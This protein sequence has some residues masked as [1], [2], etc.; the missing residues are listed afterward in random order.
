MRDN[1]NNGRVLPPGEKKLLEEKKELW[2]VEL[3]KRL[4]IEKCQAVVEINFW[5][6]TKDADKDKLEEVKKE[7]QQLQHV[8]MA[9]EVYTES[10]ASAETMEYFLGDIVKSF[11]FPWNAHETQF[12]RRSL[13]DER[14]K[15][16][17]AVL[18][19]LDH[20]I[21]NVTAESIE[22]FNQM[23][24]VV[25]LTAKR[26][27]EEL[28]DHVEEMPKSPS[29]MQKV[30]A[31]RIRNLTS[32]Y[33][34]EKLVKKTGVKGLEVTK[35]GGLLRN[36]LVELDKFLSE[37]YL[38]DKID[39][40]L[41]LRLIDNDQDDPIVFSF[42]LRHS[43]AIAAVDGLS[44]RV[45][46]QLREQIDELGKISENFF[47][48]PI[49]LTKSMGLC[50]AEYMR[51]LKEGRMHFFPWK[52]N[53][54]NIDKTA[55]LIEQFCKTLLSEEGW[56]AHEIGDLIE[57]LEI[58]L[59]KE[60]GLL[61]NTV[62]YVFDDLSGFINEVRLYFLGQLFFQASPTS[63]RAGIY[64]GIAAKHW[65]YDFRIKYEKVIRNTITELVDAGTENPT[66]DDV[67]GKIPRAFYS[68]YMTSI[69]NEWKEEQN[70]I[71]AY[72][73]LVQKGLKTPTAMD[74]AKQLGRWD[75]YIWGVAEPLIVKM[76]E[77]RAKETSATDKNKKISLVSSLVESDAKD[78]NVLPVDS[79]PKIYI[80]DDGLRQRVAQRTEELIAYD[81]HKSL[82]KYDEKTEI[83]HENE[84]FHSEEEARR[85]KYDYFKLIH[86]KDKS[87]E[88]TYTDV[89][90]FG[91][92]CCVNYVWGRRDGWFFKASNTKQMDNEIR[93]NLVGMFERLSGLY[94]ETERL[95]A[96]EEQEKERQK[97][98]TLVRS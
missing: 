46:K 90:K 76:V 45:R 10:Y 66:L 6:D 13:S 89:V 71:K 9:I 18:I 36:F 19:Q 94:G 16:I 59:P 34:R 17:Q 97:R 56:L 77:R 82:P 47:G 49:Y 20:R 28:N 33:A 12:V 83:E 5:V 37:I 63:Y 31:R 44:P 61:S 68:D 69:L 40:I 65:P 88:L 98:E 91:T 39:R 4:P 84:L 75:V 1:N 58:S 64:D 70:V 96:C 43:E 27:E 24:I 23:E 60:K 81:T 86:E 22:H 48:T 15:N 67:R 79:G 87:G 73:A 3:K 74:V 92:R 32:E 62:E 52:N 50:I 80:T 7:A 14:F 51:A 78:C 21:L 38:E 57:A 54:E 29:F 93:K 8:L 2:L 25:P 53:K 55:A 85:R 11:R 35:E 42:Y 26:A 30:W 95:K 72:D 41:L